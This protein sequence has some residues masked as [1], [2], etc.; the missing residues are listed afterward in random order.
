MFDSSLD[1]LFDDD[2][3]DP[4][5]RAY[6]EYV[7]ERDEEP[8]P[9]SCRR[10][11]WDEC[12]PVP[13]R[14]GRRRILRRWSEPVLRSLFDALARRLWPRQLEGWRVVTVYIRHDSTCLAF[15]DLPRR[16]VALDLTRMTTDH[17]VRGVLLHEMCHAASPVGG[18]GLP[19]FQQVERLLML[20]VRVQ[21]A[22]DWLLKGD[23][24]AD[25]RA[26]LECCPALR[27]RRLQRG[28]LVLKPTPASR[29]TRCVDGDPTHV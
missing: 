15:C 14:R 3:L 10:T 20:G 1:F 16:T 11:I 29:E 27:L 6:W 7:Y 18:H 22:I 28:R 24:A 26:A 25:V 5:E 12:S 4:E 19:F 8:P 21:F 13:T 2:D 23:E 17:M 9:R